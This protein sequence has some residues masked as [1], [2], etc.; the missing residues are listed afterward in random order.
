M[1]RRRDSERPVTAVSAMGN[2]GQVMVAVRRRRGDWQVGGRDD[3]QALASCR[4]FPCRRQGTQSLV[5]NVLRQEA[6]AAGRGDG[7]RESG[8]PHGPGGQS[9]VL[10]QILLNVRQRGSATVGVRF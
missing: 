9:R 7:G 6:A 1:R 4:F 10:L 2:V 5:V 3:R 8:G